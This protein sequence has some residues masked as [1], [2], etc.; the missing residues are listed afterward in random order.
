MFTRSPEKLESKARA[1]EAKGKNDKALKYYE[2]AAKMR[3]NQAQGVSSN[4]LTSLF[5][6]TNTVE[7]YENNALR[8][9]QRGNFTKAQKNREKAWRLRNPQLPADY[10]APNFYADN[11]FIGYDYLSTPLT[12]TAF[13]PSQ[14]M[15]MNAPASTTVRDTTVETH[16]HL[17]IIEQTTR[18]EKILEVQPV[19][20]RD[21]EKPEVHIVEHHIYE[22]I[23]STQP[24]VVTKEPILQETVHQTV[25]EEIQ[26]FVHREVPV[27]VIEHVEQHITEKVVAPTTVTKE[28]VTDTTKTVPV[29]P[30]SSAGGPVPQAKATQSAK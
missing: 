19:I 29:Q 9:E 18:P 5:S 21:V 27:P 3:T 15:G 30:A 14:T 22:S 11:K 26:P 23:P 20:H 4:P 7:R 10:T 24:A 8:W 6:S 16:L 17:P 28:V 12:T 25:V 13:A 1:Y 2:K